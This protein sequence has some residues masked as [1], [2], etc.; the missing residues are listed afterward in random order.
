MDDTTDFVCFHV[1]FRLKPNITRKITKVHE[2]LN[3]PRGSDWA[4]ARARSFGAC[5]TGSKNTQEYF[6]DSQDYTVFKE[7]S[8]LV[9]I[10][11]LIL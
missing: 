9:N 8:I 6:I 5:R 7:R 3:I 4:A 11:Y 1:I 10:E 2:Y